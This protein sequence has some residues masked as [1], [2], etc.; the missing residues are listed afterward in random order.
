MRN[1]AIGP[2]MMLMSLSFSCTGDS[3]PG[4]E[5]KANE[6]DV[7]IKRIMRSLRSAQGD[8]EQP[9][10]EFTLEDRM[11]HYCVPGVS[12]AV[13]HNGSVE[14]ARGY[15]E[16]TAGTGDRVQPDTLFQ[17][18]SI[19]KPLT[20]FAALRLVD[21]AVLSLDADVNDHLRSWKVAENEFTVD[22]KVTL[23][24][25]I[26]HR[27]GVN[28]PWYRG[29]R[30]GEAVPA[31]NEVL[32]GA[33][34]ANSEPVQV[35]RTPGTRGVYSGG[36]YCII[37]RLLMDVT[38]TSFPGLMG[39]LVLKPLNMG[40]SMFAQPLPEAR[41]PYVAAGHG[42]GGEPIDGRWRTYPELAAAGLWTTASD[43]ARFAIG[44]QNAAAQNPDALL[45]PDTAQMLVTRQF[46]NF[47]LGLPIRGRDGNRWFTHNGINDGYCSVMYAYVELGFGAVIMTN[48]DNGMELAREIIVA[49]AEE[50]DWPDFAP[51][52]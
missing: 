2:L 29:Y 10:G 33:S 44:V 47:S 39:R 7:R 32:A 19:S 9:T 15:G 42:P 4:D 23:R 48:S 38:E 3:G 24:R 34:P 6:P 30:K 37:Q 46:E 8:E 51:E 13:I 11:A 36:G 21:D 5:G 40:R 50:Y 52:P 27:A 43:L 26:T 41:A 17:A 45:A 18:A 31:L 25:L 14:W 22:E 20:A 28:V 1:A 16:R 12:I 35:F 49:I